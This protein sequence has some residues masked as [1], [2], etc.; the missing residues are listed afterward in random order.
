MKKNIIAVIS[1]VVAFVLA[2]VF[3]S[4][5]IGKNNVQNFQV[6]QS[7]SGSIR[8][9]NDGGYY[10]KFFASVWTY[11]KVNSVFFSNETAESKDQDGVQVVFANK[12]KGDISSQVVYRL[13]TNHESILKLHEYAHGDVDKIIDN[14]VLSKLKDISMQHA[15]NITSSQ[16]IEDREQAEIDI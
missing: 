11:P 13:Y 7:P 9:Q 16:A 3:C 8:I 4:C 2:I 1:I 5:F 15:S 14:L 10:L 12:G 6:I